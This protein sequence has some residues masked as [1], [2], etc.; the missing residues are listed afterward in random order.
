MRPKLQRL[1]AIVNRGFQSRPGILRPRVFA[2]LLVVLYLGSS[3]FF[4]NRTVNDAERREG[5]TAKDS[6][7]YILIANLFAAGDFSMS[8]VERRPHRQPLYPL[9]LAPAVKLSGN[10]PFWLGTVNI[11]IGLITVLVLYFGLLKLHS[12]L[13]IPAAIG[14]L[15][16]TNQMIVDMVSGHIMTEPLHI[17]FVVLA[18]F[19]FI[20][21]ATWRKPAALFAAAG[22]AGLDYLTRPNG[23]F[24]MLSMMGVL[25]LKE[26]VPARDGTDQQNR[27]FSKVIGVAGKYAV[28]VLIFILVSTPS[29]LPRLY[30]LHA[31][32][33]HGYLSNYMW[34][35]T[36]AQAHTGDSFASFTWRDYA[37]AHQFGDFLQRWLHGFQR[38]F[39]LPLRFERISS[40][41][42]PVLYLLAIAGLLASVLQRNR[43]YLA[44]GAFFLIQI[45]PLIWTS[46]SNPNDRVPYAAILPFEFFFAAFALVALRRWAHRESNCASS[47]C[48]RISSARG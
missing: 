29:W 28:A 36:Y 38:V 13:L 30:Y 32:L 47:A 35:D 48:R 2:P 16:I 19:S 40:V 9:L 1:L 11:W 6:A 45:L 12:N 20:H 25:F 18:V 7:H 33:S 15:Y 26:F 31:P 17:L 43:T 37:A 39:A 44:L 8:Y 14:L 22:F 5:L 27:G 41:G 24:L 23:L 4:L 10:N 3:F 46:L 21:Y 34:V 42:F